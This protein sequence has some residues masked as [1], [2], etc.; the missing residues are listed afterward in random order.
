MW[1]TQ[2]GTPPV[3]ATQIG[4]I[5]ATWVA[6]REPVRP[7]WRPFGR[8]AALHRPYPPY[9]QWRCFLCGGPITLQWPDLVRQLGRP[10]TRGTEEDEYARI[11]KSDGTRH[12]AP[13]PYWYLFYPGWHMQ[14]QRQTWQKSR[15]LPLRRPAGRAR[16]RPSTWQRRQTHVNAV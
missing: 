4:T 3:P 2:A 12:R 14:E 6:T 13:W 16:V 1:Q 9:E 8:H 7:S 10:W 11:L 15:P 5:D